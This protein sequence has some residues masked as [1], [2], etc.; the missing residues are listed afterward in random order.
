MVALDI[1]RKHNSALK[2]LGPNLV[3]VFVGGTSGIGETTARAFVKHTL[4]PRVYLIG[5]NE[6][7]ASQ[8]IEELRRLNK[9]SQ[10]S[11]IKCDVS[12]L[13][14]V[15]EACKTIQ[16]KEDK[17]NLLFMSPGIM[18]TK[19]RDETDEGVDKKLSLHYYARMR[20]LVNLLPQLTNAGTS[21]QLSRTISV[22]SAGHEGK[23]LVDDLPLKNNYS[24]RNCANHATT[25]N[26]LAMEELAASHPATSFIHAY[27]G[28][29]NTGLLDKMLGRFGSNALAFLASPWMVPLDQS[30]E[31]YLYAATSSTYPSRDRKAD[32]AVSGSDGTKGSG[33]YLLS[34]DGSVTGNQKILNGYRSDGTRKTV[35]EHTLGVFESVCGRKE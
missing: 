18:T 22:L 13:H 32:D 29:V 33:A 24:L 26:S 20:F 23:L 4:S 17:I 1:V 6:S 30:G 12:R 3:A 11:F 9:D 5:R 2:D 27:P 10:A 7:Q 14:A 16:S 15:D 8:I 28:G 31:R 25:M 34:W 19:G 35:W 21:N